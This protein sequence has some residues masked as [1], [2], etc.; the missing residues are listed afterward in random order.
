M[1][2]GVRVAIGWLAWQAQDRAR[3]VQAQLEQLRMESH[4]I[5]GQLIVCAG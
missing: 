5:L 2:R 3:R 1:M 4:L